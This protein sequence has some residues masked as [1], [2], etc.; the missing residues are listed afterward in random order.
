MAINIKNIKSNK[1]PKNPID[2]GTY[3]ARLVQVIG[4]G[5]QPQ[6]AYQGQE[7]P[8]AEEIMLTYE[9]VDEFMLDDEGNEQEDK[10]RWISETLPLYGLNSEKAKST[11]RYLVLD[12]NMEKEGDFGALLGTPVNVT[13]VNNI[14]KDVVYSN[15]GAISAMR[16]K[17][18]DN[19]PDLKNEAKVFDTENP[20]MEVF[21]KLPEWIQDKIK[22]NLNFKGSDLEK[23]L[24]GAAPKKEEPKQKPK[25]NRE[26][27]PADAED[28]DVPY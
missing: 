21:A 25:K 11:L 27:P 12:P 4:L 2:P 3:P 22:G 23:A 28:D 16:K 24:S 10:P 7:K 15:V 14:S 20:D 8:P 26:A 18:A 17:D 5:L 1:A 6:R 9:L 13:V 19:C